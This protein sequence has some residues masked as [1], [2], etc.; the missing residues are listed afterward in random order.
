MNNYAFIDGQN[1]YLGTTKADDPWRIDLQRFRV[2]LSEKY[3]VGT[4]Y[5]FIGNKIA[6]NNDLYAAIRNA[7][8]IPI[9]REHNNAMAGLKKGNVDTDIVFHIMRNPK[10]NK[11]QVHH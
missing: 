9:F 7:G 10:T 4:A 1:L 2:Y 3:H 5:Y 11:M 8:F 6:D